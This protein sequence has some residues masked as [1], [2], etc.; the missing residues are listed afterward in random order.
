M[1]DQENLNSSYIEDVEEKQLQK[2][3]QRVPGKPASLAALTDDEYT[4]I[5]R[6]A[7]LKLDAF[8]MP[9]MVI[10]YIFNYLDRQNIAAAKLAGIKEDLGIS[11]VQYQ[12]CVSILFVGYILMQVPSNIIVGKIRWPGVY[13]CGAMALWGLLS[14]LTA[15][16][17][18]FAGLMASRFFL[19]FIEAVFFPGAL[20]YMSLFY[21]RKQYALR[22]AILYSGSQ[23]GNA[24][25]G[26]FAIGIL[27]LDGRSG[28]E[29]WRW[30]FLIEG[31][32]TI[33]LAI[34]IAFVL[35]NKLDSLPHGFTQIEQEWLVWNFEED[36]GQQDNADEISAMKGALMAVTDIKTWLLMATLY[37]VY[38][39]AAVSNF[40]PSV[41]ATLGYG[42][43]ETYALTAPPYILCVIAMVINGFHSD[44]KQ[45]RYWHIV[46]PMII[47]LA[48]NIIA[49]ATLN[50]AA[51]YVAMMLM[52]GSFYAAATV[53]ISWAAGSLSQPTIK[54]A[55][56]IALIN[57]VCNTPNVWCSYLY[58][59][60][61]RYLPAFLVNL[62]ASALAILAATATRMYLQRE[63]HKLDMGAD[64]GRNG[65]TEAQKAA[66]FRYTL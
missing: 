50:T 36:Q 12:T 16:V 52:P 31:V 22:T 3:G 20:F 64:T 62:A 8:I 2:T 33:A 26:L 48:A 41:V 4:K 34:I 40:F 39:A 24:F 5:G 38:I 63:N 21:T 11:D 66:G 27:E 25:G 18:N 29:G 57:A 58:G 53:V 28:M 6:R 15:I 51:R 7:T 59:S 10:M 14:A 46:C 43:N 65:P 9:C 1:A 35:P 19:G 30:L 54:R 47:C 55:S 61:P 60:S 17:H 13:I 23:L 32:L 37:T 49:V 44:R 42:R 45:E 56:A